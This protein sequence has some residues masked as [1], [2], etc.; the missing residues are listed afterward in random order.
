MQL[1]GQAGR[2]PGQQIIPTPAPT[3]TPSPN[4]D[5]NDKAGMTIGLFFMLADAVYSVP[6]PEASPL[7]IAQKVAPEISYCSK[8][9]P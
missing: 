1:S 8:V 5:S 3:L 9:G 6:S 2:I 7:L 4:I